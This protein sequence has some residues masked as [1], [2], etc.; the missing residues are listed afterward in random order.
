MLLKKGTRLHKPAY[1]VFY[2]KPNYQ[3]VREFCL[4]RETISGSTL[5][6]HECIRVWDDLTTT[7]LYLLRNMKLKGYSVYYVGANNNRYQIRVD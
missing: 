1:K 7:T 3:G 4:W 5:L 6:Y 2:G